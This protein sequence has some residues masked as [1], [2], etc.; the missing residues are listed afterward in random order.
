MRFKKYI[1]LYLLFLVH[2]TCYSQNLKDTCIS[3]PLTGLHFSG[4]LAFQDLATRYGNT[5]NVG[6]PFL[7]KTSKNWLIGIEG[8][9]FF[10]TKINEENHLSNLKNSEGVITANDGAPGR[11]RLT[12]R[13]L[14]FYLTIGKILPF[15]NV[16]KNCG[17]LVWAGA[18]YMQHKINIYDIGK[19]IPQLSGDLING[20]DRLTGGFAFTGFLGYLYLSQNKLANFYAGFEFNY[21]FTK[22]LRV[23]Q[24]DT[25]KKD[26]FNRQDT[27]L[28]FRVGWILPLYKRI[29]EFYYY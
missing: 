4:Q 7:Y 19:N 28:G 9:Y 16:N 15:F 20:Y 13:G 12:E 6:I 10:G 5:A 25:M 24:F 27:Q 2:L 21:G 3:I 18:G 11:L 8:N 17:P 26:N 23:Y 29:K 1:S 22:S 14:N